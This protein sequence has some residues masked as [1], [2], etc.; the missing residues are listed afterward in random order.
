[1]AEIVLGIGCSH[2]PQLHTPARQWEI[3]AERDKRDGL[4]LWY[5]G[6][7]LT[8]AELEAARLVATA[9]EVAILEEWV[10][11]WAPTSSISRC[12]SSTLAGW[13]RI[14]RAVRT[15]SGH[16]RRSCSVVR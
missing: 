1:M 4:P 2:T 10:R 9:D 14:L 7:R 16:S 12:A 11:R 6:R 3:R 15:A 8:Y 5:K 13:L